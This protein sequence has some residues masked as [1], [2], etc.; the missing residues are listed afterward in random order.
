MNVDEMEIEVRKE[1]RN[2]ACKS[3]S[4]WF[5]D[6]SISFNAI[7]YDSFQVILELIGQYSPG[8][9]GLSPYEIRVLLLSQ[10]VEIA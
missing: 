10:E 7:S 5:Y 6:A 4:R 8:L 1:L 9:K 3:I 2:H